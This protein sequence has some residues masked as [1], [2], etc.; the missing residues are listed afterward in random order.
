MATINISD[1]R[2]TGS[3]LFSDSESYMSE[4]GDNELASVNGG[5]LTSPVC[6]AV[7]ARVVSPHIVRSFVRLMKRPNN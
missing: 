6:A 4:L 2:P 5:I 3:D 7:V 1:L